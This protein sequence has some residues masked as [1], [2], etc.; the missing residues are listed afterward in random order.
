M[1]VFSLSLCSAENPSEDTMKLLQTLL[2]SC[3]LM[4]ALVEAMP[5]VLLLKKR[6]AE[7]TIAYFEGDAPKSDG[8]EG[9][10]RKVL[11]WRY[12]VKDEKPSKDCDDGETCDLFGKYK[13]VVCGD[14]KGQCRFNRRHEFYLRW[15]FSGKKGRITSEKKDR[16]SRRGKKNKTEEADQEGNEEKQV[17]GVDEKSAVQKPKTA[18]DKKEVQKQESAAVSDDKGKRNERKERKG[19]VGWPKR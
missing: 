1:G 11:G 7:K 17:P 5:G 16:K 8:K 4:C 13:L 15:A 18:G 14:V 3:L 9:K 19:K 6:A 2:V 12:Q 10:G